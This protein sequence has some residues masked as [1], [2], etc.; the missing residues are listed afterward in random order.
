[1]RVHVAAA[2][3]FRADHLAGGRLHQ[4]RA[5]QEDGALV[6]DDDRLVAHG[7]HVGAAG[8]ARAH[9]H[10]Q[11][12]D[13]LRAEVG[14]VVEDAAEVVAAS[15][16]ISRN[17]V[18][19]SSRRS[20][21]SRGSSLPRDRCFLRASSPP[22]SAIFASLA[23]RSSTSRRMAAALALKSSER[24]FSWVERVDMGSWLL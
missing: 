9:H 15:G 24:A 16:A 12:R 11:L 10:G 2:E 5:A 4:R 21:R 22:P 1:A 13:A 19:G 23:F 20:T 14:L 6:L 7:R 18:P 8:G 3:V 17:G